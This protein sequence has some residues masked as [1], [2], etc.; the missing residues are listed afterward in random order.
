[1][2]QWVNGPACLCK[3]TGS[4]PDPGQWVKDPG[5][6]Q[7]WCRLQLQLGFDPWAGKVHMSRG[8]L[9]KKKKKKRER[10]PK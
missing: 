3:G 1:M 5:L 6:L 7:L 4:M 10:E 9:K 2:A 8:Q